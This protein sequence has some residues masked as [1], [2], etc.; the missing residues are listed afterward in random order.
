MRGFD[1]PLFRKKG[2]QELNVWTP[3]TDMTG[4]SISDSDKTNGS[5]KV[6]D[7]IA[8]NKNDPTD[9]WLVAEKFFNDNYEPA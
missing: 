9:R 7:M 2:T 3:E 1:M 8:I 6:G 5:P 4:V